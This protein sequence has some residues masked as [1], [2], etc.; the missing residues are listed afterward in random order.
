[1]SF[2]IVRFFLFLF[3]PETIHNIIIFLLQLKPVQWIL[4]C[5]YTYE[6]SKLERNF[7]GL[8]FPNPIGLAAGFDKNGKAL[9]GLQALGFGFIEVGT[10][11]PQPQSGSPRPRIFRFPKEKALLNWMGFNNDGV[12]RV[13]QRIAS[14][15]PKLHIPIGLN[16]G[17]NKD[18]PLEKAADDYLYCVEKAYSEVDFFVVNISSPNTPQLR[19]LQEGEHI[20]N[21][22]SRLST[23]KQ[24]KPILIKLSPDI[25]DETLK[26]VIEQIDKIPFAGIVVTNTMAAYPKGGTSGTPLFQKSNDLLKK[27]REYANSPLIISGV[28]GILSPDDAKQ[29]FNLGADLIE[30]Y[31]G[32]IY[33]GPGLVKRIKQSLL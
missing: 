11:T 31:T 8:R 33:S 14:Q 27:S 5:F 26:F 4:K 32:L 28:G 12:D 15:R 3:D 19:V 30:L 16:I 23:V 6:H 9:I 18:T 17:K 10:V 1:M 25:S 13:V 7:L 21:L 22:L 2:K 29:K 24:K 20:V